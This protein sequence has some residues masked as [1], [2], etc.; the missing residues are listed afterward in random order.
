MERLSRRRLGVSSV[1][2][3]SDRKGDSTVRKRWPKRSIGHGFRLAQRKHKSMNCSTVLLVLRI[4]PGP[5]YI[6]GGEFQRNTLYDVKNSNRALRLGPN[7]SGSLSL[8]LPARTS[9]LGPWYQRCLRRESWRRGIRYSSDPSQNG[10]SP[11]D[12]CRSSVDRLLS[13][14]LR[15]RVVSPL[16]ATFPA[17]TQSQ[18]P[19]EHPSQSQTWCACPV[20]RVIHAPDGGWCRGQVRIACLHPIS[21]CDVTRTPPWANEVRAWRSCSCWGLTCWCS[22]WTWCG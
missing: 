3:F 7:H 22:E 20:L 19:C 4:K 8:R 13:L 5:V 21:S 18:A 2:C 9:R 17:P 6:T 10:P 11:A 16:L 14:P 1:S 15:C 12:S